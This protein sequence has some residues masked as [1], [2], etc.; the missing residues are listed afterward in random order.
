MSVCIRSPGLSTRRNGCLRLLSR[1]PDYMQEMTIG[2]LVMP[3]TF[4]GC[5]QTCR[6][7]CHERR[8]QKF[9]GKPV[10]LWH[11]T[12]RRISGLALPT[13]WHLRRLP[14]GTPD[15]LSVSVMQAHIGYLN[16]LLQMCQMPRLAYLYLTS[17]RQRPTVCENGLVFLACLSKPGRHNLSYW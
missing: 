15:H 7:L 3:A 8:E 1:S 5:R 12:V 14:P 6:C 13:L 16:R 9:I 4:I 10:V 17:I 2:L 11:I